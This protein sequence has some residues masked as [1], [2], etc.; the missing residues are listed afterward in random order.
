M[1]S[2]HYLISISF[3]KYRFLEKKNK[4]KINNKIKGQISSF[5]TTKQIKTGFI[6]KTLIRNSQSVEC[7]WLRTRLSFERRVNKATKFIAWPRVEVS[8]LRMWCFGQQPET[9]RCNTD[10][11][12]SLAFRYVYICMY[13]CTYVYIPIF[14]IA[15]T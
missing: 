2:T 8:W 4:I 3:Q 13:V 14:F 12:C 6:P 5:E 7:T 9:T 15:Y 11:T 10:C 1:A